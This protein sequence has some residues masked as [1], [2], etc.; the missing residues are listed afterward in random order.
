MEP[1]SH[2]SHPH[3][4]PSAGLFLVVASVQFLTRTSATYLILL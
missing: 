4:L 2:L 3:T 1:T